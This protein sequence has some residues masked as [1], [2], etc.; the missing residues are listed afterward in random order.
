MLKVKDVM[1]CRAI[2]AQKDE[3]VQSVAQKMSKNDIGV[4]PVCEQDLL[5]G[6]V[7]DRDIV[8][9]CAADDKSCS[10]TTAKEIMT[11]DALVVSPMQTVDNAAKI[12]AK[13]QYKRLP[14]TEGGKVIGILS[15]SDVVKS[16][17]YA[18]EAA[19]TFGEISK[20]KN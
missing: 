12:M 18:M 9:R 7:T 6:I 2:T 20:D 16:S 10:R 15:L 3:S 17:S 19:K 13:A 5:V 4:I 8:L 14:V 11:S 1:S